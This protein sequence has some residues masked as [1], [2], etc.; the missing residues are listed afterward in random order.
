MHKGV[1]PAAILCTIVVVA[2]GLYAVMEPLAVRTYSAK[3]KNPTTGQIVVCRASFAPALFE[4]RNP[5]HGVVI[6]EMSCRE[7]GFEVVG[8]APNLVID[9]FSA[10]DFQRAEQRWS[11][12]IPQPCR[13]K[14]AQSNAL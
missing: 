13:D 14:T 8:P 12:I 6:C 3:L 9:F 10:Q 4:G 2:I 11:G 1:V 5:E 7:H